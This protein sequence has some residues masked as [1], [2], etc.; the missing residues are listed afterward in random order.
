MSSQKLNQ[1]ELNLLV[2]LA[3]NSIREF[4]FQENSP[5]P[6]V[7]K[8]PETLA[9][10]AG[11]FVTLKV[12][13]RL[14]GCLGTILPRKPLV[15]E[16]HEMAIAASHRDHRFSP[17]AKEQLPDLTV[18]VSVLTRPSEL[19]VDSEKGLIDYLTINKAGVILSQGYHQALF[20]PQVWEQLPEP[21]D[22]LKHLKLKA[23]WQ[24]DYWSDGMRVEI[25]EVISLE[26]DY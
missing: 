11:C 12:S 7:S 14:Q 2:D 17:L 25:F 3:R 8:Y 9:E 5:T 13:G 22:F 6:Q 16:V 4:L 15:E 19:K 18:E 20:L 24:A 10:P 1:N 23:G 26:K 21:V